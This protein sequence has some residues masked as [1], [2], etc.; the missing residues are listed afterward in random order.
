MCFKVRAA[1][2]I[3]AKIWAP[4]GKRVKS[5]RLSSADN[6][7]K[8]FQLFFSKRKTKYSHFYCCIWIQHAKCIQMS[9]NRPSISPV[10]CKISPRILRKC[11]QHQ[12]SC[13][14]AFKALTVDWWFLVYWM[15]DWELKLTRWQIVIIRKCIG[16]KI[17]RVISYGQYFLG[18]VHFIFTWLKIEN[19]KNEMVWKSKLKNRISKKWIILQTCV[20]M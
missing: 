20:P 14:G 1:H 17:G 10:V 15:S 12:N 19:W 9:A 11:H 18:S 4:L 2:P 8:N 6:K 7:L 5:M 13:Q 16:Y 3:Q